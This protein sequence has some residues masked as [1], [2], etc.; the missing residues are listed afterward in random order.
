MIEK[1][2]AIKGKQYRVLEVPRNPKINSYEI[3]E[4]NLEVVSPKRVKKDRFDLDNYA[5]VNTFKTID[6][7]GVRTLTRAGFR[8]E[9]IQ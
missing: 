5:I 3:K 9:K 1:L 8:I 6:V 2:K 4:Q 7:K